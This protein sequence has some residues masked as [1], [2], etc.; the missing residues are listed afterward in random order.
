MRVIGVKI[1]SLDL[2]LKH[3]QMVQDMKEI[4]LMAKKKE[5]EYSIL[6]MDLPMKALSRI[7]KYVDMVFIY[8]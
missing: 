8:G 4:L 1:N 2:E 3:G 5:K 7:M 6:L